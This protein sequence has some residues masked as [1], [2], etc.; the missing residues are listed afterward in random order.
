MKVVKGYKPHDNQRIIH[1]SINSEDAKYYVLCIGRQWGKTLLCINQLLYWAINSKGCNI[2]WVSPIYKQSKKVYNDLKKATQKS[3]YFSYNDSELIVKGFD[4]QIT[5]YS[6]ERPDNIRGNTFDYLVLDEFDFMKANTWEEVLQPTVLVRGK[7]VVFISTPKGKRMMYKLSL[8]RHQD[9]R[10][11]FF[12]FSSY[13]N[14]MIDPRE[15]DSIRT[16]VP[17][18]IFRQEYLADFID[19]GSGVFSNIPIKDNVERTYKYF[20]GIDLGRADDYTVLTILN[21]RAEMVYCDRWRHSSWQSIVD[22]M[23]P[24]LNQYRPKTYIEVNSIGDVIFEQIKAICSD[25]HPFMTTSK[26]K[27]E[28]VEALQVAIQNKEFSMMDIDWLKKEFDLFTY[29]YSAKSRSIKY[30]A[31]VGFHDDGVMSCCIA[32]QAFK[33]LKFADKFVII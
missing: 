24:I 2:G 28:A 3:G 7:K 8:L 16:N 21:E 32:Y 19:N 12:R 14:P 27:Q 29:E 1:N 26:S 20:A 18:H 5:F 6:A 11:R 23:V 4:S 17:E 31:P 13:D 9:D 30:S 10:Y 33:K 25:I 15:I 22:A